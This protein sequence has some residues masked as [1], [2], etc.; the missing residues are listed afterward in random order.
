MAWFLWLNLKLARPV[1]LHNDFSIRDMT[2]LAGQCRMGY[3]TKKTMG[4][5]YSLIS[6]YLPVHSK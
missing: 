1:E 5:I 3:E 2:S 4:V 6:E